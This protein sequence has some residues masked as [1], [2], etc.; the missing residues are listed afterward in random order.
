M[1]A[2]E[3][4]YSRAKCSHEVTQQAVK[5]ALSDLF[6]T[7]SVEVEKEMKNVLI[8]IS[9]SY[10]QQWLKKERWTTSSVTASSAERNQL[11]SWIR[12][13]DVH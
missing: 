11:L 13:F 2:Q 4:G 12:L 1:F 10:Y 3:V 5:T 9:R 6:I 8:V 7:S